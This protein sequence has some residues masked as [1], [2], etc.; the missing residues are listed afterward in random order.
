MATICLGTL[1]VP[2]DAAV[3]VA[4]APIVRAFAVPIPAIQW[5]VI[6]YTLTYASLMLVFGRIGDMLGYRRLFLVGTG[7]SAAAFALCA[8]APSFGWLLAARVLQG[9]GAALVVSCGPALATSLYEEERR[10]RILGFYTMVFG[11][12]GALGPVLAGLLV[13][14]WGWSSVFTFRVPIALAAFALAWGLPNV[15]RPATGERFDAVGAGLL[16]LAIGML[17]LTLNQL[18]QMDEPV[19]WLVLSGSVCLIAS[20]GFVA[21]ER[22]VTRPIID[23]R[24]F[25]DRDFA[26]LNLAHVL[27]NLAGFAVMLLMP[28]Y[29][30]RD[31]GVTIVLSGFVLAASPF[32]IT[33]AAPLAGRLAGTVSPWRLALIGMAAMTLGQLP[34]GMVGAR[35]PISLLLGAMALQGFG[36]GLFQVAYFDLATAT[37]PREHRGV[38]G[39]LVMMTRTLGIVIGATTLMLVFQGLRTAAAGGGATEAQAF[40]AGFQ[41]A[42][43]CAAAISVVVL[44]SALLRGW[45][46]LR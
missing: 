23:L 2:F 1:L 25:G 8:T 33:L 45:A 21:Q 5:V 43:R 39:S 38:A 10:P 19:A 9:V 7:W 4:F 24:F 35:P 36:L 28:F 14:H 30:D 29:L 41:G 34:I 16:V 20:A 44:V 15:A 11:V 37:I 3:N 18:Q 6:S 40:L 32:G 26:L 42:F 17:V 13:Q 22:R 31:G 27:L 46:R 12:G